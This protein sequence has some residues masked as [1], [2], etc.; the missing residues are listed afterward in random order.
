MYS[1]HTLYPAEGE[2]LCQKPAFLVGIRLVNKAIQTVRTVQVLKKVCHV[3]VDHIIRYYDMND[4]RTLIHFNNANAYYIEVVCVLRSI[5]QVAP[6]T[7]AKLVPGSLGVA[8]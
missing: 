8:K 7:L 5:R 4:N 3:I 1:V 2:C 6:V